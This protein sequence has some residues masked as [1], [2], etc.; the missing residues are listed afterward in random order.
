M[1]VLTIDL[2]GGNKDKRKIGGG[3]GNTCIQSGKIG[4][5]YCLGSTTVI[6]VDL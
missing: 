6:T 5:Y 1:D 3:R 2:I 4:Y